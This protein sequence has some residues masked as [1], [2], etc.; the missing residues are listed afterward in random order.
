MGFEPTMDLVRWILSPVPMPDSGK[1]PSN[2]L[3]CL[4]G[5]DGVE[6]PETGVNAFTVRPATT[7]G[8]PARMM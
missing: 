7:Y 3:S 1:L 5:G 8:I 6:P 4:M 2:Y